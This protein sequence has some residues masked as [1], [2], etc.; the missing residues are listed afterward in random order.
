ML[1]IA[2]HNTHSET[3]RRGGGERGGF[4]VDADLQMG[5]MDLRVRLF[6]IVEE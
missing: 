6:Q 1:F 4:S 5:I 3:R 2:R